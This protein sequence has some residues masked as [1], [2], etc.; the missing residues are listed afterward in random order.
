MAV[1]AAAGFV[2]GAYLRHLRVRH[3]MRLKDAASA[4]GQSIASISRLERGEMVPH[5]QDVTRLLNVYGITGTDKTRS[6]QQL[7]QQAT[8]DTTRHRSTDLAPGWLERL[9]AVERQARRVR[10]YAGNYVPGLLQ[11]PAYAQALARRMQGLI[12]A[13]DLN[14][15]TARPLAPG[16]TF[17]YLI[18]A[19]LESSALLRPV[20]GPEVLADQLAHLRAMVEAGHAHIHIVLMEHGISVRTLT[21]LT[22]GEWLLYAEDEG[23][24]ASYVN[25]DC[26]TRRRALDHIRDQAEPSPRSLDLLSDPTLLKSALANR[27]SR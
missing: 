21:E 5:I 16:H 9:R 1:P 4:T 22:M 23:I 17:E 7:L 25:N 24:H 6:L 2:V 10:I 3:D 8:S 12:S 14:S 15:V 11:T 13:D 26:G 19:W 20:G 18:E 27:T